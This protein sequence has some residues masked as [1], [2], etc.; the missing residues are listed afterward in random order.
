[1]RGSK[2]QAN[3]DQ[4]YVKQAE[5]VKVDSYVDLKCFKGIL[6]SFPNSVFASYLN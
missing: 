1:M 4:L 6:A 3:S 2:N 5:E